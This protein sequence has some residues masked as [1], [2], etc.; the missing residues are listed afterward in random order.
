[1]HQNRKE[2]CHPR[3]FWGGG[4]NVVGLVATDEVISSAGMKPGS[5]NNNRTYRVW[6]RPCQTFNFEINFVSSKTVL[7]RIN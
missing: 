5:G 7:L 4:W 2:F 6:S 1:M 3:F